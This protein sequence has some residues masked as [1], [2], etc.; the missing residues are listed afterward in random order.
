MECCRFGNIVTSKNRMINIP[1]VRLQEFMGN[2]RYLP[3]FGVYKIPCMNERACP[4]YFCVPKNNYILK[5][6]ICYFNI[7]NG[8]E[9]HK[10]D[11]YFPIKLPA[12]YVITRAIFYLAQRKYPHCNVIQF[13]TI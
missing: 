4:M 13:L 1:H 11:D 5:H 10:A 12:L 9:Y 3:L 7:Q 6:I 2:P 8:E